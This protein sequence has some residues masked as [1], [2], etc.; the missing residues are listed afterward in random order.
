MPSAQA[1]RRSRLTRL[2][3][4]RHRRAHRARPIAL[5]RHVGDRRLLP[6]PASPPIL[7]PRQ[8]R[9]SKHSGMADGLRGFPLHAFKSCSVNRP[10][11]RSHLD[12]RR[13]WWG[14]WEKHRR[15]GFVGV[16][17][18]LDRV[19]AGNAIGGSCGREIVVA[20]GVG[21]R[22]SGLTGPVVGVSCAV[23]Q[24]AG[25]YSLMSPPTTGRRRIWWMGMDSVAGWSM[26]VG[27]F[28][29]MPR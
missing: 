10:I 12:G 18:R 11:R 20:V 25:W 26:V 17:I 5:R 16:R 7:P 4:L 14:R 13:V 21:A 15:G 8:P 24:A 29:L 28:W 22:W 23:G 27:E 3:E 19:G 2:R 6:S 9:A 1:V